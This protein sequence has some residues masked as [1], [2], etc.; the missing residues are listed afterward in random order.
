MT[1]IAYAH[2]RD[3]TLAAFE[4]PEGLSNEQVIDAVKSELGAERAMLLVHDASKNPEKE[5]A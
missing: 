5:T 4:M 2:N 1:V 3:G